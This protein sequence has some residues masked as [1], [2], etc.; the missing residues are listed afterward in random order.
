[1]NSVGPILVHAAQTQAETRALRVRA[2]RLAKKPSTIPYSIKNPGY[3][4]WE[5]LTFCR[6]DPGFLILYSARSSTASGTVELRRVRRPAERGKDWR[7]RA[8]D[9]ELNLARAFSPT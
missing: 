3:Y 9:T 4:F 8:A 6:K 7:S 1:V 2:G 5:S